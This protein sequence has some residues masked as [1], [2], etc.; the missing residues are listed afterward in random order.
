MPAPHLLHPAAVHFPIAFLFLGLAAEAAGR[1][2]RGPPWLGDAAGVLLWL[3]AAGAWAA[4]GL[5]LVAEEYAPHVPAAWETL[6]DHKSL[7]WATAALFS[8]LSAWRW[9]RPRAAP[10]LFLAVW[11]AACGLLSAT[12]FE[13]GELVFGHGMGISREGEP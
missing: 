9:R 3:G 2:R 11:L 8:V 4:L 7:A 12:A 1:L 5:G 10:R 6:E 13:G